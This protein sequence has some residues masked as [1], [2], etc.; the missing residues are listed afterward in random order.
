[1]R[2][3]FSTRSGLLDTLRQFNAFGSLRTLNPFHPLHWSSALQTLDKVE[4]CSPVLPLL[5]NQL[6]LFKLCLQSSIGL[7]AGGSIGSAGRIRSLRGFKLFHDVFRWLL[8][9]WR[10]W[11]VRLHRVDD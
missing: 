3:T 1:M 11:Q 4:S 6:E 9:E 5:L 7:L 8:E 2:S 10:L